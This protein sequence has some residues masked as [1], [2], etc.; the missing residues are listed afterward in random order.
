MGVEIEGEMTAEERFTRELQAAHDAVC[1]F[2]FAEHGDTDYECMVELC[3]RLAVK[4]EVRSRV[5]AH[6]RASGNASTASCALLSMSFPITARAEII[7]TTT[8]STATSAPTLMSTAS[9]TYYTGARQ[10]ERARRVAI[11]LIEGGAKYTCPCPRSR[12]SRYSRHAKK[13]SDN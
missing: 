12:P 5:D 8:T 3:R 4:R 13:R 10:T 11:K 7:S 9:S 1:N 6:K 2:D